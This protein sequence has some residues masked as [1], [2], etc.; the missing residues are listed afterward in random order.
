MNARD[1]ILYPAGTIRPGE[2]TNDKLKAVIEDSAGERMRR[3]ALFARYSGD[4]AA[5]PIYEKKYGAQGERMKYKIKNAISTGIINVIVN[6]KVGY[7]GGNPIAQTL[8]PDFCGGL[9]DTARERVEKELQAVSAASAQ[10]ANNLDAFRYGSVCGYSGRLAHITP[11]GAMN[12]RQV[13]PW[14]CVFFGEDGTQPEAALHIYSVRE[15]DDRGRAG[16]IEHCDYYDAANIIR[17]AKRE[18]VWMVTDALPH[19]FRQAPLFAVPN[20]GY[21]TGDIENI[22]PLQDSLDVVVSMLQNELEEF[23]S[24]YLAISGP[25]GFHGRAPEE[26]AD[27]L[28]HAGVLQLPEGCRAEWVTKNLNVEA[29]KYQVGFFYDTMFSVSGVPNIAQQRSND[30]SGIA[31]EHQKM[32]LENISMASEV[33]MKRALITQNKVTSAY[34]LALTGICIDPRAID[35]TLTRNYPQNLKDA[36]GI[37]A[38]LSGILSD[39]TLYNMFPGTNAQKEKANLAEEEGERL[40]K[41]EGRVDLALPGFDERYPARGGK[42]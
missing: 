16:T 38:S 6:T 2:C 11:A 18:R 8:N 13:P 34:L 21:Y 1:H 35:H 31:L 5:I 42:G 23:A 33:W 28:R 3:Y 12:M 14:E 9:D 29:I 27:M 36:A 4:E 19:P 15:F 24:A 26:V 40:A 10:N 7:L 39:T 37:L 22:L 41:E 25:G 20:N 17:F 32:P 30:I